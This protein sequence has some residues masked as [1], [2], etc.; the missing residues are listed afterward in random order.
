[1]SDP[2][3]GAF[4]GRPEPGPIIFDDLLEG[5]NVVREGG[6]VFPQELLEILPGLDD[7][8]RG[9]FTVPGET[10]SVTISSS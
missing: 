1:M 6:A 8:I 4:V 3:L 9:R 7:D 5:L 2:L 10:S